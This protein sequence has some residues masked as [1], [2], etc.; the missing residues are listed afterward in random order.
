MCSS[1]ILGDIPTAQTK[2]GPPWGTV[3]VQRRFHPHRSLALQRDKWRCIDGWQCPIE[4]PLQILFITFNTMMVPRSARKRF[5]NWA[6]MPGHIGILFWNR[7][8]CHWHS[9]ECQAELGNFFCNQFCLIQIMH[10]ALVQQWRMQSTR[11]VYTK[12]LI[13]GIQCRSPTKENEEH[14]DWGQQ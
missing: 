12:L 9:A 2:R 10:P 6:L 13:V 1:A 8:R 4:R 11:V 7:N 3:L 5:H 14:K